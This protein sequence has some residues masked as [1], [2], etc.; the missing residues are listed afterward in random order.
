MTFDDEQVSIQLSESWEHDRG[1]DELNVV[2]QGLEQHFWR[3]TEAGWLGCYDFAGETWA[4]DGSVHKCA[5]G[6]GSICLQRPGHSLTVRVG[7]EEEGVSSL[8]P[9]LAAI[10]R[11]DDD[12]PFIIQATPVESDLLYLCDSEAALNKMSRWIGS[13]PRTT[14][15]GD[16]NTDIMTTIIGCV[17]ERFLRGA[18]TFMVKIKAHQGEPLNEKADTQAEN[19]RRLSPECQQ[20]TTCTQRM[21]YE[22]EDSN[23]V[24]H[25]TAW[26]KAVRNAI[27]R[28]GAEYQMRVLD[29]AGTNWNKNFLL[30]A[31]AGKQNIRQSASAGVQSDLMD[32]EG[33]GRR[34]M[35]Q[36]QETENW[37]KPAAA[38]WAAEFLLREG[39]S[40][41][42]L[43]SWINSS[44]VH[45]SKKRR[46]K[47]VITCSFPC[48][49]WL[50][51]IGVRK[52]L[53]CELCRRERRKD[54]SSD[55]AL[56]LE[57]VAYL[58]SAGCKAQKKS[59]IGGTRIQLHLHIQSDGTALRGSQYSV[60]SN[61]SS[62]V[63]VSSSGPPGLFKGVTTAMSGVLARFPWLLPVRN[64]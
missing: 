17:R 45:E 57:T 47:Q 42:C 4:G 64:S 33:W 22:W 6:A 16:A 36:L 21:T 3:G 32:A 55:E 9:E 60:F 39:E 13:N 56:P 54:K 49:K 30:S 25:V 26:S 63:T 29:R 7:R 35:L 43:G 2:L 12:D 41:E 19:A 28:G 44:A 27:L 62:T 48:G 51:M 40:R 23:G 5:M 11:T 61:C 31:D 18:R 37:N 38:T 53:G 34:C 24:Q 50:H 58:Q 10:A 1:K 59:V 8:R 46:D 14:L 15:A 52:S 20:W